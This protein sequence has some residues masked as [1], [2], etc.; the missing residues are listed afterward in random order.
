MPNIANIPDEMI[1]EHVRWHT[2][3]GNPADGGRSIVPWLPGRVE[4][5]PGSGEEFLVWH[6]GYISRFMGW[7]DS[8]PE[9]ER[10]D[11][12]TIAPWT[13]IPAGFKMGMLGWNQSRAR[14]EL[15]LQDMANFGTH[16]ELGR[17]LE[18][19]LHGFLHSA[20][21]GMF[22]ES[23]IMS[24]ESPR[25]TYFWQLHGLIEYWSQTWKN[26]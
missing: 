17:F 25:S 7:V 18:W 26:T 1:E 4:P 10:P 12:T 9:A 3:E 22:N 8:L 5:T 19:G 15:L 23:I 14:E 6:G 11:R 16:D 2:R 21:A 20:A 24:W 13:S